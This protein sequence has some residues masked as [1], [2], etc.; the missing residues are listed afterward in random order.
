[1][2]CR[3]V[4][5]K[6]TIRYAKTRRHAFVFPGIAGARGG[7]KRS[8]RLCSSSVASREAYAL[9]RLK[10]NIP[11]PDAD[12]SPEAEKRVDDAIFKNRA[13]RC[14]GDSAAFQ[15]STR[16]PLRQHACF[17]RHRRGRAQ[18]ALPFSAHRHSWETGVRAVLPG[19][20]PMQK[21][22]KMAFSVSSVLFR[23]VMSARCALAVSRWML[24]RS[25]GT[26]RAMAFFSASSASSARR[27]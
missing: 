20:L 24:Q 6:I 14:C 3:T 1:M 13:G 2:F 23:P 15:H 5:V 17:F 12:E 7:G 18:K 10:T 26:D 21:E 22:E 27:S 8:F 9:Q 11:P 16:K 25:G 4:T 19:Y